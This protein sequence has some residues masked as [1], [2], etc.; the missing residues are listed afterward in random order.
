MAN[1]TE[2][3]VTMKYKPKQ[4][5]LD[6]RNMKLLILTPNFHSLLPSGLSEN[7]YS[8]PKIAVHKG[9]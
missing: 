2:S 1:L 5:K 4:Y 8:N 9:Q 7:V 6:S 3:N